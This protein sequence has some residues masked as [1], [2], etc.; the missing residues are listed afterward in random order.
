MPI[1]IDRASR[2]PPPIPLLLSFTLFH[3]RHDIDYCPL[4]LIDGFS[5]FGHFAA[6]PLFCRHDPP[7]SLPG[8]APRAIDRRP[9][10]LRCPVANAALPCRAA[11]LLPP[12]PAD[13]SADAAAHAS[14]R[15]SLIVFDFADS[16]EI[17]FRRCLILLCPSVPR[18]RE[19]SDAPRRRSPQLIAF[20]RLSPLPD[21][22]RQ[23]AFRRCITALPRY[24]FRRCRFSPRVFF[25]P[26]I[27]HAAVIPI[28]A[29]LKTRLFRYWLDAAL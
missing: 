15:A 11:A 24:H 5:I 29:A 8:A 2:E 10:F 3:F 28:H 13:A 17:L 12:S 6:A 9:F 16:A 22:V 18:R 20:P 23:R 4:L 26:L 19:M 7:L 14:L 25:M 1:L 21:A 27:I